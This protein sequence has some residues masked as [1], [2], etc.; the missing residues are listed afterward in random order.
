MPYKKILLLLQVC[1]IGIY[2][3][4]SETFLPSI[5]GTQLNTMLN[6]FIIANTQTTNDN[7]NTNT[8]T[9]SSP[10]VTVVSNYTIKINTTNMAPECTPECYLNCQVH[11]SDLTEEKYC[12]MNVCKCSIIEDSKT[13]PEI[14]FLQ[15]TNQTNLS[16]F[17][18][19]NDIN[20]NHYEYKQSF[21]IFW[22]KG[23]NCAMF[24]LFIYEIFVVIALCRGGNFDLCWNGKEH[25]YKENN[26]SLYQQLIPERNGTYEDCDDEYT[27]L[28][29]ELYCTH[30]QIIN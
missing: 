1:L 16:A 30:K 6:I 8:N 25:K 22:S 26:S 5:P 17:S 28:N 14:V 4:S 13:K 9:N 2:A 20:T 12:I 11:F 24:V 10:H 27:H 29:K 18:L 19:T 23:V 21:I 3:H 15:H 7:P